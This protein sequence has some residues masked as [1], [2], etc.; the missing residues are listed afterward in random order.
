[1]EPLR[2]FVQNKWPLFGAVLG[3]AN[4]SLVVLAK[5]LFSLPIA[6]NFKTT[7]LLLTLFLLCGELIALLGHYNLK[8]M[9]IFSTASMFI[10]SLVLILIAGTVSTVGQ[11]FVLYTGII[12]MLAITFAGF[13]LGLV[14]ETIN[15]L[16][17]RS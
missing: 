14:V 12:Y 7:I 16:I 9:L 15:R 5:F 1:M 13:L 17:K 8:A 11:I 3:L 4:F 10:G 6:L 2:R